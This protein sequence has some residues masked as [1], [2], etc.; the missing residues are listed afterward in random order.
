MYMQVS[1]LLPPILAETKMTVAPTNVLWTSIWKSETPVSVEITLNIAKNLL[2]NLEL[3]F[4]ILNGQNPDQ[5]PMNTLKNPCMSVGDLITLQ[6]RTFFCASWGWS[7][8]KSVAALHQ[9][10]SINER[11]RKLVAPFFNAYNKLKSP[12]D[13]DL[14]HVDEDT[15]EI[16]HSITSMGASLVS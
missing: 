15:E 6:G 8:V 14:V 5:N 7:E 16:T 12:R 10:M 9:F 1:Y 4:E 11:D 13:E 2:G 3:I